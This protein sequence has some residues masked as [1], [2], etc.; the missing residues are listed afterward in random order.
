MAK[1]KFESMTQNRFCYRIFL[2]KNLLGEVFVLDPKH[3][4]LSRFRRGL[5]CI[6]K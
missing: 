2:E 1:L 4:Q 3:I 6:R 5:T